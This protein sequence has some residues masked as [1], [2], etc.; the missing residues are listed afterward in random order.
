MFYKHSILD[1]NGQETLY[2]YLDNTYEFAQDFYGENRK[3]T[4]YEKV[5]N[6][7][8]NQGIKFNGNKVYLVVNGIVVSALTIDPLVMNGKQNVDEMFPY[9]QFVEIL[10]DLLP[11]N[12]PIEILEVED[13]LPI[14][15]GKFISLKRS[16]GI[17]ERF[18]L[19][20]YAYGVVCAEMPIFFE[21][22]AKKAQA[23]LARTYALR[24][25]EKDETIREINR[26]QI[27][28]D[29]EN[30]KSLWKNQY[31]V[32]A[33][34]MAAVV[35]ETQGEYLSYKG[36]PIQVY[37]HAVNHGKTEDARD[38]LFRDVPYLKSVESPWDIEE[39][40]YTDTVTYSFDELSH[41]LNQPIN[42]DTKISV[43]STTIGGRVKQLR[44]GKYKYRTDYLYY[45]LGLKSTDFA[46]RIT[47]K[48]VTFTF[49]ALET[50]LGLSKYGANGMAKQ[51]YDYKQ[52][53]AHYFPGTEI[54]KIS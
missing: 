15:A 22:E 51:G 1:V 5:N 41:K 17:L 27:F 50:G 44:I 52:I 48:G 34:E 47:E 53:L 39:Y 4:I 30:L 19:E 54:K 49:L 40:P 10:T 46:V 20:D 24:Q 26:I 16:S 7:I 36:E 6:Y 37:T 43:V 18:H 25:D 3:R 9:Y 28:R 8:R 11:E 32:Y 23:V 38:F 14:N 33:K 35:K 29:K 21:R 42:K 13:E 2:L 45:L 31:L 12:K